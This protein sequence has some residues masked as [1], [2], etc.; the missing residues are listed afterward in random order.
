MK[1][2][3]KSVADVPAGYTRVKIIL[4]EYQAAIVQSWAAE[5][6]PKLKKLQRKQR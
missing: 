3:P 1:V 5:A 2:D 4:P 6:A